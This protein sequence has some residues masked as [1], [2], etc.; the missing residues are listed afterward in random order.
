[1]RSEFPETMVWS[2]LRSMGT[3]ER[4]RNALRQSDPLNPALIWKGGF[5][6]RG[7]YFVP[8]PNSLWHIGKEYL[9]MY[10]MCTS[11]FIEEC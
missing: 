2:Q 4:V 9:Y 8:G 5:T 11:V 10:Q 7:V 1:M 6:R 3:R